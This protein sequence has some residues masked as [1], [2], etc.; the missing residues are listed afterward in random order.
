MSDVTGPDVHRCEACPRL[1]ACRS[2]IVNGRGD[3][4]ADLV[5]VGEAPGRVE[6]A[7]GVP[8][9]GRSGTI[10]DEAIQANGVNPDRVRITNCVRCRPPE[11]RDPRVGE[12]ANCRRHLDRELAEVDPTVVLAL[13]RIPAQELVG[14]RLTVTERAGEVL[15]RE[16]GGATRQLVIGLHPAATLYDRSKTPVFEAALT[17]AI[18]LADLG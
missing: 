5:V 17:T 4:D 6:D 3:A 1:V 8:F 15:E 2:Q 13:G 10:L 18:E 16:L 14:E 12:R 9:V 7:E 11:N